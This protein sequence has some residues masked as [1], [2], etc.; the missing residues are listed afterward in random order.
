MGLAGLCPKCYRGGVG[1]EL[2]VG[3]PRP[4]GHQEGSRSPVKLKQSAGALGSSRSRGAVRE[5][6]RRRGCCR[7]LW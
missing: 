1:A 2:V 7:E 6:E 5:T 3:F 4:V